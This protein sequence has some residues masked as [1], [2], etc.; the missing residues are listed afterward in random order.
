MGLYVVIRISHCWFGSFLGSQLVL[1]CL[2]IATACG[3]NIYKT[4]N[5]H[6][7]YKQIWIETFWNTG[8]L[9]AGFSLH[10]RVGL[11]KVA[12]QRQQVCGVAE[13]HWGQSE[14]HLGRKERHGEILN[15]LGGQ[16]LFHQGHVGGH[17]IRQEDEHADI[18]LHLDLSDLEKGKSFRRA[19]KKSTG[20]HHSSIKGTSGT[21]VAF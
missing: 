11:T 5:F 9:F 14:G 17:I 2:A 19:L 3:Y 4:Y 1:T 10:V 6:L 13:F 8:T 21:S 12:K 15:E 18:V 20:V 16:T 7:E